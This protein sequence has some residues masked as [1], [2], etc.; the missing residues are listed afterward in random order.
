MSKEQPIDVRDMAIIHRTFR[1]G[2]SEAAQLVRAT[3]TPSPE[4]VR[5]LADHIDFA[6]AAMHIHHESEDELLYPKLIQRVPEQA[7]M[8]EEVE[9]EHQLV[10][11]AL[12]T[13]SAACATWR[14]QPSPET[15]EALAAALEQLNAVIQGHLDD[16]EQDILP[17]AAVTLTKQ[18]WDALGKHGLAQMPRNKRRLAFGI[19]PRPTRR[20]R[21]CLHEGPPAGT[22]ADPLPGA[23]RATLEE[24]RRHAARRDLTCRPRQLGRGFPPRCAGDPG[25]ISQA[26]HTAA[27][28]SSRSL[29]KRPASSQP[30]HFH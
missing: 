12:D 5:F 21:P 3:P 24:V 16:E 1:A 2:Y 22:G 20:G 18:E 29:A 13:A 8:T 19:D 11:T 25:V 26:R 4:R 14:G 7:P 28:W 30:P 17:L 15:G 6:I 23:D 9:H 27:S 10:R